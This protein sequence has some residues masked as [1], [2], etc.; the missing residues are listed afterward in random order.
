MTLSIVY[1]SDPLSLASLEGATRP[2]LI[3]SD[4]SRLVTSELRRYCRREISGRSI[5]V[6]GHRGGGKTTVVLGSFLSLLRDAENAGHLRP[7]LVLLHGP[8]LL[9]TEPPAAARSQG[10]TDGNKVDPSALLAAGAIVPPELP[11]GGGAPSGSASDTSTKGKDAAQE[12]KSE[13]QIALE[14]IT[15]GLYRALAKELAGAYRGRALALDADRY[16]PLVERELRPRSDWQGFERYLKSDGEPAA[17]PVRVTEMAAQ[18]EL[19]LYQNTDAARLRMFW[20][21]AKALR[22][23]VV[24]HGLPRNDD[25]GWREL[26]ALVSAN[27]AYLRCTG[28]FT[29]QDEQTGTESRK[30]SAELNWNAAGENLVRPVLTLLT[31]GVSGVGAFQQ[32]GSL[33]QSGLAAVIGAFGAAGVLK[34]SSS[35][36]R[37][38]TRTV[39]MNFVPDTSV[40][41]L[42]RVLPILVDRVNAAGLAPVF[43]VDELDKVRNLSRRMTR[44]VH[45]LKKFVA[46]NAFFCW[47]TDR[48]Y[49]E[50]VEAGIKRLAYARESTYFTYRLFIG[51][52]PDD[53]HSYLLRVLQPPAEPKPPEEPA[54]PAS[55]PGDAT[56][57]AA[58]DALPDAAASQVRRASDAKMRFQKALDE[59]A[60]DLKDQ[61]VWP[62]V[63]MHRSQ[64]HPIDLHREIAAV[65]RDDGSL[66]VPQGRVRSIRPYQA[67]VM[68]QLAIEMVLDQCPLRPWFD[69]QPAKRRFAY[70]ALY[71]LS[72]GWWNGD[73]DVDLGD[74]GQEAF[75]NYLVERLKT[76]EEEPEPESKD[77]AAEPKATLADLLKRVLNDDDRKFL[78][79]LQREIALRLTYPR[80]FL[81]WMAL[82]N[83]DRQRDGRPPV[84]NELV[85]GLPLLRARRDMPLERVGRKGPDR[86]K[87]RWRFDAGGQLQVPLAAP[88]VAPPAAPLAAAAP[89]EAAEWEVHE[90]GIRAVATMLAKVSA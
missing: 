25:Q 17:P 37:E 88:K 70:D 76:E 60:E 23:G 90:R 36:S 6:A 51:F 5:L 52:W 86:W 87:F 9:P 1:S 79:G 11:G 83:G 69:R 4:A 48:T 28:K 27:E 45:D 65:R 63:L 30:T 57:P 31:G 15:I 47:L 39:T 58:G 74:G 10:E 35:V 14:Q 50:E 78:F 82:W 22:W 71:Y 64:M 89:A 20:A 13:T 43:V 85:A 49:Y 26:V 8:S 21:A 16:S 55:R 62:Y 66:M 61:E 42:D 19:D 67:D 46:E 72:R 40:T 68:M 80:L 41:T 2:I 44:L 54:E 73:D 18:L 81:R 3:E 29:R 34:L 84:S 56:P 53:L 32:S 75:D 77:D 24:R 59:R 38:R 7:L 12:V 33:L